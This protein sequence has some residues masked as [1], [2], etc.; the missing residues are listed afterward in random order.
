[1]NEVERATTHEGE[2]REPDNGTIRNGS[3]AQDGVPPRGQGKQR[4]HNNRK[5]TNHRPETKD[6]KKSRGKQTRKQPQA[7]HSHPHIQIKSEDRQT[8]LTQV[9]QLYEQLLQPTLSIYPQHHTT[10][11]ESIDF[12]MNNYA[13]INQDFIKTNPRLTDKT[14]RQQFH[15]QMRQIINRQAILFSIDIEAWELNN[16]TITEIGVA[17]YDP[18]RQGTNC[19]VPNFTKLHIRVL[20]N[21]HRLNGKFVVDH[22]L[23]FIGEPTLIL[24]MYDAVVLI[25]SLFDYFFK[26]HG[27]NNNDDNDDELQT[28]LVGHEVSGDIKWLSSLGIQFPPKLPTLD[29]L[30]IVKITHGQQNLSLGKSL[31]KLDLPHVFLHNA[32]NDAYYTLLLCLKLMDPGVRSLYKLDLCIDKKLM[33]SEEEKVA[34]KEEKKKQRQEKL[35]RREMR[36]LNKKL[37]IPLADGEEGE[38]EEEIDAGQLKGNAE[39]KKKKSRKKKLDNHNVAQSVHCSA[40]NA[41]LYVFGGKPLPGDEEEEVESEATEEEHGA[42]EK[43]IKSTLN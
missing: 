16:R 41:L 43:G 20:E 2:N 36:K 14:H 26:P 32:G 42:E 21:M 40:S 24:N 39:K 6:G 19:I 8:A 35:E 25:Q 17:I 30:Q 37:G 3:E 18:R 5:K 12:I 10:S 9:H 34:A 33:M 1:M 7:T 27:S 22:A 29:T 15:H 31:R 28:Y 23:H 11:N 4:G 13:Y 38:D